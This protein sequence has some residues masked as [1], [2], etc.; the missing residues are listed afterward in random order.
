MNDPLNEDQDTLVHLVVR[1]GVSFLPHLLM[2]LNHWNAKPDAPNGK[3]LTPLCVAG[4]SGSDG[5]A[6]V[7]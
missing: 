3:G 6:E 7:G 2:L 4:Q 5:L 1:G